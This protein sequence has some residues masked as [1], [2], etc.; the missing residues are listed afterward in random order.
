M[1]KFPEI[2]ITDDLT[3]EQYLA[4]LVRMRKR[5]ADGIPLVY[6]DDCTVGSKSTHCSW[7]MCS[8][9]REQWPNALEHI[10]P[11]EFIYNRRFAPKGQD[12]GQY[13]PFDPDRTRILQPEGCFFKCEIFHNRGWGKSPPLPTKEDAL[14]K[15]DAMILTA[16]ALVDADTSSLPRVTVGAR[17]LV[18][19]NLGTIKHLWSGSGY[20]RY[21]ALGAD[22]AHEF[23]EDLMVRFLM[24]ELGWDGISPR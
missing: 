9:D 5:I 6:E 10:W 11:S 8:C 16:Q 24:E 18:N 12:K 1:P 4:A 21:R 13:C 23:N 2:K 22:R 3:H 15:Y 17:W 20:Y 19:R 7:G 14:R